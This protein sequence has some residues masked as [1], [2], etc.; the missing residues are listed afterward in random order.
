MKENKSK[1]KM[2][3]EYTNGLKKYFV[4]A[5][6]TTILGIIFNYLT[7]QVIR[8]TVDSIIG[9]TPFNLPN[10]ILN[11][12]DNLGEREFLRQ[13]L[14]IPATIGV[15]FSVLSGICNYFYKVYMA[16]ASDGTIKNLRD[17][18]YSHI[19]RLPFSWHMKNPT[20]DIIQRCT[21]DMEVVKS[22][23]GIQLL[24]FIRIIFLITISLTLMFSMNVK[25]SLIAVAFIL[26]VITYSVIFYSLIQKK[27]KVADEAEGELSTL[28]Q[29][30]FTGV[31]VVRAFGRQSYEIERF[32]E[33]NIG[34]SRLWIKLGHVL[35]FYWGIGD[36]FS[37][38]QVMSIVV[39]GCFETV[40]G[41]LTLGELLAFIFY[42]SMLVWPVR[43]LGRIISE[44]GKAGVSINRIKEILDAE[45]ERD[46]ED[47]ITPDINGDIEFK[48]VKFDYYGTK[49][50]LKDVSF[51]IKKGSTFGI[52]G[53]TG[54][55]KSTI[56]HLL[57]RLY[58][59]DENCGEILI[60]GV[61]IKNIKLGYLRHN[62]GV[63]LQEPFLFS[64]TIKQNI[65]IASKIDEIENFESIKH[66]SQVS[67]VHE[68]ILGFSKGYDTIVGER[69]VTL[70]GG[71]KQRVAIAR[72]LIKNSPVIV[73]DDSLSA[74]DTET[75]AKIRHELKKHV[76]DSTVIII[77]HRITTLMSCDNIIVLDDG[78]VI[79]SGNHES[80]IKI[81]GLYKKVYDMQSSVE[82]ELI[83]TLNEDTGGEK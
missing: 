73:F 2:I 37:G 76:K 80:L 19:S 71:Q 18:L 39:F 83:D 72:T 68:N 11:T 12:I 33:K 31:R 24:E 52:L 5:V 44:M 38:L 61:N 32:D 6:I 82:N 63:V 55:G 30:N 42:N 58:N 43:S 10:Y 75:D 70:S 49:P 51:K 1:V 65:N 45:E 17:K 28:V 64:K 62:I 23:L 48:N 16:K 29:E 14:Y 47:A 26:I 81:N 46:N 9:N 77:S 4:I 25:L 20:G 74:V 41:A 35:S 67:H 66:V 15:V 36:L 53:G 59:L 57:N 79:E 8:I 69:G 34:F 60:N 54:S 13:N 21:S 56:V 50:V 7:P 3:I 78:K 22:F 40:S 27:F